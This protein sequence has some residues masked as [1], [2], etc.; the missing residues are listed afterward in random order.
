[1]LLIRSTLFNIAF[2]GNTIVR[3]I[4]MIRVI[5]FGT[6]IQNLAQAKKWASTSN[7]M[8]EKIAGTK[9]EFEGLEKT[10][11]KY[12]RQFLELREGEEF[13]T[14]HLQNDLLDLQNQVIGKEEFMH[15]FV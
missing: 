9:V 3:L 11:E 4:M 6:S 7:T 13:L 12:L 10:K 2:Y 15:D 5:L 8:L 1:M 14:R